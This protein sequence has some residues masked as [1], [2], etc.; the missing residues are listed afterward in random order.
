MPLEGWEMNTR[1]VREAVIQ[2]LN[3]ARENDEFC[4]GGNL[5]QMTAEH[6]ADDLAAFDADLEDVAPIDIQP[7][8]A[9]WMSQQQWLERADA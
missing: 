6:V 9:E 3:N 5:Y 4:P 8:V 1:K 7:H 2:A